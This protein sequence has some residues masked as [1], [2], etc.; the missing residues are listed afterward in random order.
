MG[1][2]AIHKELNKLLLEAG[3]SEAE[4]LLY[5]ELLKRPSQTKWGLVERTKMDKNKIY[6]AFEKLQEM[7]L[8][9]RSAN[10]IKALSLKSLISEL[11]LQRRKMGKVSDRLKRLSPFLRMPNE[12]FDEFEVYY[13]QNQIIDCYLR[14]SEVKYSACLD[15]G[16]LEGFVP[17]LGG[18][19]PVFEF[20][21]NRYKQI[22]VNKAICTTE[23]P[24]TSCMARKKDM[25]RYKSNINKLNLNF[26]DKWIIFSDCND[27]VMFNDFDDEQY[28]TSVLVKSRIVAETQRMYFHQ[29]S[30]N[31]ENF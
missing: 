22:A 13:T 17:I 29:F 11:S 27:F 12:S 23:G 25:D 7:K 28:P 19:A 9:E 26:Q 21:K 30:Q 8:V 14:M 24:Y 18:L 5:I 31:F 1:F 15:F 2:M 6:R 4:T 16:D 20:R 3:L 10:G